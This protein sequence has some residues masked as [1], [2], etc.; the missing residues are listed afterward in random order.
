LRAVLQSDA[1]SSTALSAGP[2]DVG[3]PTAWLRAGTSCEVK[4]R[5]VEEDRSTERWNVT[6]KQWVDPSVSVV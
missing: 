4:R 2:G 5:S 1:G 6:N 3:G